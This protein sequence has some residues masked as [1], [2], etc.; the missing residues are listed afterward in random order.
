MHPINYDLYLHPDVATGNF[1]GQE[2]IA[3]N[4][5][6]NTDRI[7]LHSL[8]MTIKN[9]YLQS[10]GSSVKTFYLDP[11]REFLVIELNEEIKAPRVF[12]LGII[13]EGSMKNKIIGLYS[14]SYL[15]P[16]NSVK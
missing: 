3:I 2:K 7:V 16:D 9:V 12:Y 5:T 1:S 15:K 14:S 8:Y 4:C 11:V 10:S 13:F 6:Q